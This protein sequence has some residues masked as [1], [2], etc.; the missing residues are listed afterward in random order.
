[1]YAQHKEYASSEYDDMPHAL[2]DLAC[3][4][5]SVE[6]QR[7]SL[8]PRIT[9][10]VHESMQFTR[11]AKQFVWWES[12]MAKLKKDMISFSANISSYQKKEDKEYVLFEQ[13]SVI[14]IHVQTFLPK[15]SD[16]NLYDKLHTYWNV[17][18]MNNILTSIVWRMTTFPE[19]KYIPALK[20]RNGSSI[21]AT[22]EAVAK[23]I[24]DIMKSR[25][26]EKKLEKKK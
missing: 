25:L 21:E 2:D 8:L 20:Q 23:K 9:H 18:K 6:Q 13:P 4:V 10:G 14:K 11:W 19:K 15:E 16:D 3:K 17:I 1:M 7:Q 12:G 26:D 5:R 22:H 24:I